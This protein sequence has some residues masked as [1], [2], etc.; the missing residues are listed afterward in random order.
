MSTVERVEKRRYE[1]DISPVVTKRGNRYWAIIYVDAGLEADSRWF[2]DKK[3]A[4]AWASEQARILR[5]A[6]K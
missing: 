5:R 6:L 2:D 4:K 1:Q 3:E